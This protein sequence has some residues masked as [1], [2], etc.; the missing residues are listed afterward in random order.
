[1]AFIRGFRATVEVPLGDAG[2]LLCYHGS[3]RSA[4]EEVRGSTSDTDLSAMLGERHALMAGGHTHEQLYR[5][6]GQAVV[7]N[8]GSVGLPYKSLPDGSGH[9][10]LRMHLRQG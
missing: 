9:Y 10:A 3:P 8:P 7:I 5:R 1:M 4:W 6:L 2:A